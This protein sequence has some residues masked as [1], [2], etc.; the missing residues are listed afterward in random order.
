MR[1]RER[2]RERESS[3]IMVAH[4]DPCTCGVRVK[5]PSVKCHSYFFR[6]M[7]LHTNNGRMN[8]SLD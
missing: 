4:F 2:E 1:E 3:A 7:S 5:F 8:L 6:V